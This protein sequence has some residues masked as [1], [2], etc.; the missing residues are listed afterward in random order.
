M[1]MSDN[2]DLFETELDLGMKKGRPG[3][4]AGT[5]DLPNEAFISMDRG[6]RRHIKNAWS[7]LFRNSCAPAVWSQSEK[8]YIDKHYYGYPI[9]SSDLQA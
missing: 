7:S 3:K 5:D 4:A 8:K 9:D 6:N 2:D 1:N